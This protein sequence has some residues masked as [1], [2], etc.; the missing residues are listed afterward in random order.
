MDE[1]LGTTDIDLGFAVLELGDKVDKMKEWWEKHSDIVYQTPIVA[2]AT[3]TAP[4]SSPND[5]AAPGTSNLQPDLGTCWSVRRLSV[6][7]YTAGTVT[8]YI[9]GIEPVASWTFGTTSYPYYTYA[10][11]AILL[12]P[13]DKLTLGYSG[14]T[15][16][17]LLFGSADTF[18]YWYLRRYLD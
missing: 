14:V 11:G 4:V 10:K 3:G 5:A 17:A 9:N 2:Q 1:K 13:G 16:T 18:P 12:Q 15:G 7:G 8:L 6:S